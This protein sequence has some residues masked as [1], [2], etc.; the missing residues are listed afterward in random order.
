VSFDVADKTQVLLA[1]DLVAC[2]SRLDRKLGRV[3]KHSE[4]VLRA[5]KLWESFEAR[6]W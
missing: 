6:E 3:I 1:D 5:E 4:P 2:T